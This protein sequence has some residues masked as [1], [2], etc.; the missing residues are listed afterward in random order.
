MAFSLF[1]LGHTF[2]YVLPENVMASQGWTAETEHSQCKL[3]SVT[4][5]T[6]HQYGGIIEPITRWESEKWVEPLG[7]A[8]FLNGL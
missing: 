6:N 2:Q 4:R 3:E 8:H 1:E 5:V 7:R